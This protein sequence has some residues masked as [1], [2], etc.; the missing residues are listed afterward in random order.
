DL[1]R[2]LGI[3]E[4]SAL[5]QAR[6]VEDV[7]DFSRI[8]RGQMRLTIGSVDVPAV[9][10]DALLAVKPAAAAKGIRIES[11]V[12]VEERFVCDGPRLQQVMWN[13]LSNAIKFSEPHGVVTVSA[14]LGPRE[15]E[16]SVTDR[17]QG[18]EPDF[19]PDV[20]AAF[21]QAQGGSTRRHGGLGLGLA[22]VKEIVQAHGGTVEAKS[23]GPGK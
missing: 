15:L 23:D 19:L 17:G 9:I 18:I 13:L 11:A 16:L 8:A 2:A 22:I 14:R 7:L 20:F 6:I 21:R 12:A 3:I 5:A 10:R 1:D 4:K